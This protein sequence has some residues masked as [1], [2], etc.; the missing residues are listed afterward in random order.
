MKQ[1]LHNYD[2]VTAHN[3][4]KQLMLK[5][6][7][8]NIGFF[9]DINYH[10]C[11]WIEARTIK[12]FKYIVFPSKLQWLLTYITTGEIEDIEANPTGIGVEEEYIQDAQMYMLKMFVEC[13]APIQFTP[14]S[15]D[16]SQYITAIAPYEYGKVIFKVK[17]TN[18]LLKYLRDKNAVI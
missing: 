9:T 11:V 18:E 14:L 17:R 2:N 4:I 8:L 5:G 10:S 7:K 13:K 16:R 15:L 6:E 3:V 1:Q 12:A